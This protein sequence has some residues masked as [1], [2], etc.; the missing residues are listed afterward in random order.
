M[1]KELWDWK[2]GHGFGKSEGWDDF[3]E[4]WDGMANEGCNV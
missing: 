4:G 1:L 2:D 3:I